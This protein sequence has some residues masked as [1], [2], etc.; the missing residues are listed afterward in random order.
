MTRKVLTICA[1]ALLLPLSAAIASGTVQEQRHELMESAKDAAKPVAGM[2]KGEKAFDAAEAMESFETWARVA[3]QAGDLFPEGSETGYGTEAKET[4]WT[5]R[6]GFEKALA[7][8]GQAVDA[9]I[10]AGPQDLESLN[11]AAGPVFKACKSCH[12]GYR[13]EEEE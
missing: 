5:D 1:A 13:V 7:E 11:A 9:A 8:F 2:L 10:E 12:E 4:V 3:A 6:E